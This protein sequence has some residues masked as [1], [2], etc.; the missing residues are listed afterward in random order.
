MGDTDQ[1]LTTL[2]KPK[3]GGGHV[4]F[5]QVDPI[6]VIAEAAD[7]ASEISGVIL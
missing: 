4:S 1:R 7:H 3:A 2:D 5:G 6:R